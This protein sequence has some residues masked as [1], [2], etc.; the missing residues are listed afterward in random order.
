L[1]CP[2]ESSVGFT[3]ISH[4]FDNSSRPKIAGRRLRK[5]A[6]NVASLSEFPCTFDA[7]I[8]RSSS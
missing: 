3:S 4:H 6:R 2:M 8:F 1:V 7:C 5:H